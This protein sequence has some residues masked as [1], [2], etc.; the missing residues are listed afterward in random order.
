M[1]TGVLSLSVEGGVEAVSGA[2]VA[3]RSESMEVESSTSLSV[4]TS[5]VLQHPRFPPLQ[6]GTDLDPRSS[7]LQ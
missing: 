3:L 2:E 7:P 1:S 5:R 6:Q 4:S